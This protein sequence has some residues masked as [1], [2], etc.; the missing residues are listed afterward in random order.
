MAIFLIYRLSKTDENNGFIYFL[1][2]EILFQN[3][4]L[5]SIRSIN[6]M[7]KYISQ[8]VPFYLK[9]NLYGNGLL[10]HSLSSCF[11]LCIWHFGASCYQH[12][13]NLA[14]V[15]SMKRCWRLWYFFAL[16]SAADLIVSSEAQEY[17]TFAQRQLSF[18][19]PWLVGSKI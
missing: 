8:W 11:C 7:K 16:V 12:L 2:I 1:C 15:Y 5:P 3:N 6:E 17:Y 19:L 4:Y 9:Y 13:K 14:S 10:N 18:S